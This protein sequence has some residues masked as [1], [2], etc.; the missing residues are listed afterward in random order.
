MENI[1]TLAVDVIV[2]VLILLLA[3]VILKALTKLT[4][5][6]IER[7]KGFDDP[8]RSKEVITA[9]TLLRSAGRY[10]IYFIAICLIINQL[11]FG[12]AVSSVV[13]AAGVGALVVSLG[14][15][16]IIGDIVAGAFIM[17]EKQYAV[18]DYIKV[19]DYEGSVTSL[20]LR[21]TY[22]KRWTGEKIIIPNGSIKTV[23]NYSTDFNMAQIDVP[24]A[25]EQDVERIV[26]ILKEIAKNYAETHRD[27]CFEDPN[28]TY[29]NSFDDS[30]IKVSIYQKTPPRQ[31]FGVQRD[32]RVL[33]KKR[34]DEEGISI[35]YNQ[36]VVHNVNE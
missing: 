14:A 11:G 25:Y 23:V 36:I 31:Y 24:V 18:G 26:N 5:R 17:F 10:A 9:M 16:S 12:T 8:G 33:I 7:A 20:A 1:V 30:S 32:L 35:P 6:T 19:N 13:T 21:C 28:V 3:R 27:T 34:F 29:I 2:I 15:Q 22:L 4:T